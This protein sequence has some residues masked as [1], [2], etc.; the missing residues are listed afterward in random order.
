MFV[1]S[2]SE[3]VAFSQT[4]NKIGLQYRAE[5]QLGGSRNV[6][7]F[8]H[9]LPV[10]KGQDPLKTQLCSHCCTCKH[11]NVVALSCDPAKDFW[12]FL[13]YFKLGNWLGYL[14]L[15][16]QHRSVAEAPALYCQQTSFLTFVFLYIE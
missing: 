8:I 3:I 12:S 16:I 15:I 4:D 13:R 7:Q 11:M 10:D 5:S 2:I 1:T 6:T 9:H 14:R